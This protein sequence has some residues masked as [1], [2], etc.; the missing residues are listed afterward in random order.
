[1]TD[2]KP[3]CP[4]DPNQLA[5]MIIDIATGEASESEET[6]FTKRANKAGAKGGPTRAKA[7]TPAERSE[8]ASV[9]WPLA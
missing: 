9:R 3:K 1:M 4:R 6:V 7:L 5:M 2:K 8:I